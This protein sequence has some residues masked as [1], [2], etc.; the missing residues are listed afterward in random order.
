MT[1]ANRTALWAQLFVDELARCGLQAVSMA[2]GSRSTPLVLAFAAQRGIRTYVHA[3]ERS[4][5]FFALGLALASRRPVA[6][7]CTSGTAAANFHPAVIEAYQAQVPLLVLTADR[8]HDQRGSGA[9]QTIDQVKMYGDHAL[10]S[11]EV[12]PPEANPPD[13]TLRYLRTL[14]C[15]ALAISDGLRKGPVH[16]NFPFRKP[17]ENVPVP[18]DV[19]GQW[20]QAPPLGYG[21]RVDHAPYTRIERGSL[22]PSDEGVEQLTAHITSNRKGLIVCGP[23]CPG[24][25]FPQK[26]SRLSALSGYPILADALSGVRFGPHIAQ[27]NAT[28]LGGYE[29][30]LPTLGECKPDLVLRFGAMPISKQVEDYLSA[31]T[32]TPQV[33][34]SAHGVWEDPAFGLSEALWAEPELACERVADRLQQSQPVDPRWALQ[35]QTRERACWQALEEALAQA[36]ME[37]TVMLDVVRHM[38]SGGLLYAASSLPVR[39]LDQFAKPDRKPLRALANRGASGID[40]TTSSALGA[41]AADMGPVVLVTGDLAFYHD[42]SGLL[43]A[44]RYGLKLVI[45][46]LNNDGGGIFHRLPIARFEPPFS[47]L[48]LTPHG[49]RFEHIARLFEL[50]YRQAVSRSEFQTAFEAALSSPR[51]SLIEAPFDARRNHQ[52]HLGMVEAARTAIA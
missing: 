22:I 19:P 52:Q 18:G 51:S 29:T 38:P 39:H 49:L 26:I 28:I 43:A 30:F 8:P 11:V 6:M 36:F 17:L 31:L 23:R 16:L 42:L 48:F 2:P 9:N 44:K 50:E 27:E 32:G 7:L 13:R 1:P 14:A 21:G 20:M 47:E 46:L 5:A 35:W 45:V 12:A 24:G 34:I 37:E 10:W 33:G 3:D 41:A 25:A 15:R 40:G 4:A